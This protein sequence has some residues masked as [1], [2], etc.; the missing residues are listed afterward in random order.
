MT[1]TDTAPAGAEW[2]PTTTLQAL[3]DEL[4][5]LLASGMPGEST[6][7][8]R[9]DDGGPD[10]IVIAR[11][12]PTTVDL[13]RDVAK[14]APYRTAQPDGLVQVLNGDSEHD[15]DTVPITRS[16]LVAALNATPLLLRLVDFHDESAPWSNSGALVQSIV[17]ELRGDR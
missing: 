2:I 3:H 6:V 8:T 13:L 4:S 9:E 15:H 1:D 7:T 14:H 11:P 5:R 17:A 10:R 16:E 12:E